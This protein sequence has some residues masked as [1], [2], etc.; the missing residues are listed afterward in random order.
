MAMALDYEKERLL[1]NLFVGLR[2]KA[3]AYFVEPSPL[4]LRCSRRR[5]NCA[6]IALQITF[7]MLAA[8]A[9]AKERKI[10]I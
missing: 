9:A 1:W 8:A 10:F 5:R 7:V 2:Q 4:L 3:I 6:K